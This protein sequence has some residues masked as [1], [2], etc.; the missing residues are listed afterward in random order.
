MAYQKF[1]KCIRKEGVPICDFMREFDTKYYKMKEKK[2]ELPDAVLAFRLIENC[3]LPDGQREQV[4]AATKPLSFS[5][6]R[7]TLKRMFEA[8]SAVDAGNAGNHGVVV[9]AEPVFVTKTTSREVSE[10]VSGE[11]GDEE[12]MWASYYG[13]RRGYGR[14]FN[15]RFNNRFGRYNRRS[16]RQTG[17]GRDDSCFVCGSKDH[18]AR[19]CD[20]R[21]K[22]NNEKD[23]KNSEEI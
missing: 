5:E 16:W 17:S 1:E 10:G 21:W 7:A 6:V 9:K 4:M 20:Q 11:S 22:E 15:G 2:M 13:N 3:R 18:W 23:K 12:V 14:N 8:G 19:Y